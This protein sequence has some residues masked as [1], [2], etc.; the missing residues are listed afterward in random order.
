[1]HNLS[2]H[3]AV[4]VLGVNY[5]LLIRWTAKLPALK[6]ARGKQRK[7][8]DK[9]HVRQLDSLKFELLVWV[10]ARRE[11]EIIVTKAQVVFKASALLHSFR[12]KTF[13]AGFKALSCFLGQH[14][15]L[16]CM[17]TN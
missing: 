5:A 17:K 14:G 9:G 6:V 4:R 15:Y 16:Y 13:E 10:F 1:M 8:A 3:R 11:Q 2:L 12:A 7:S